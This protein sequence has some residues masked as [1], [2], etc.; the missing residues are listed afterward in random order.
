MRAG[1]GTENE[2]KEMHSSQCIKGHLDR[3]L[4]LCSVGRQI[5]ETRGSCVSPFWTL[6]VFTSP[7]FSGPEVEREMGSCPTLQPSLPAAHP[8]LGHQSPP[9][10]CFLARKT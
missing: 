6:R 10:P 7:A 8:S 1:E 4:C 3:A 5:H 9:G 2:N